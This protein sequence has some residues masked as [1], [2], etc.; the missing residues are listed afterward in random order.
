M[1][2]S[3][4]NA[5]RLLRAGDVEGAR[6]MAQHVA[7]SPSGGERVFNQLVRVNVTNDSQ[8]FSAAQTVIPTPYPPEAP[9][10]PEASIL[11][12]QHVQDRMFAFPDV[13]RGQL[14][15]ETDHAA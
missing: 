11:P 2:D 4:V 5:A 1:T 6:A 9:A 14:G 12:A 10:S 3:T 13:M 8:P 15:L 7:G